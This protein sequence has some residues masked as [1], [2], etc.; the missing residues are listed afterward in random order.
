MIGA[1]QAQ[2]P[3]HT[4][5]LTGPI[6]CHN[7][8]ARFAWEMHGPDDDAPVLRGV[9]FAILG[10]DG[11]LQSVTGFLDSVPAGLLVR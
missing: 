9:D 2:F 3:G 4:L 8:H 5:H 11:R 6:D 10:P 7:G 1:V